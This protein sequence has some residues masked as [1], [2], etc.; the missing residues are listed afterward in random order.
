MILVAILVVAVV[1]K[2]ALNGYGLAPATAVSARSGT[3][4][5]RA[6]TPGAG[7]I[8]AIDPG[9]A[10][11]TPANAIERARGVEEMLK[12]QAAEHAARGDGTTP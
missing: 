7:G 3:P 12:Q 4:A 6:R 1:A 10:P 2:E 8:E 5:D 11:V 9:A